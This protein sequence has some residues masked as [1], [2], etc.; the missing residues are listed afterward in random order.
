MEPAAQAM[1]LR[2]QRGQVQ[3]ELGLQTKDIKIIAAR[4]GLNPAAIRTE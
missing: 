3:V 1:E 2:F 4:R